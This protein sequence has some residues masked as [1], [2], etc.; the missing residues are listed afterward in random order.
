MQLAVNVAHRLG[1]SLQRRVPASGRKIWAHSWHRTNGARA[2]H[3]IAAKDSD[4]YQVLGVR[5][6]SS[7][8]EIKAAWRQLVRIH[9]PD[10]SMKSGHDYFARLSVAFETL[11]CPKSR[12]DYDDSRGISLEARYGCSD[13]EDSCSDTEVKPQTKGQKGRRRRGNLTMQAKKRAESAVDWWDVPNMHGRH[14][15]G[16]G[17]TAD[18]TSAVY[19]TFALDENWRRGHAIAAPAGNSAPR[20]SRS[21]TPEVLTGIADSDISAGP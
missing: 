2:Q 17:Y 19:G 5:R 10:V 16:Y 7:P 11:S 6:D 20:N 14:D 8:A 3:N 1:S 4:L 21:T 13:T 9:H 18:L 12:A 15:A